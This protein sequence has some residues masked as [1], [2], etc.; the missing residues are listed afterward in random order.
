MPS[1]KFPVS[2]LQNG[3]KMTNEP[4]AGLRANLR[5]A[6]AAMPAESFEPS[7]EMDA[8]KTDTWRKLM[9]GLLL[10]NAVIL[11]RRKFGPLGW[12][13]AYGFTDSD[14]DICLEQ[15]KLLVND[16]DVVPFKV[17][18]ELTAEVNYGGRVTDTWDRRTIKNQLYDFIN[19]DVLR[20]AYSFSPSGHYKTIAAE[21]KEGY[22]AMIQE[23]PVNAGPEVFGLHDNADITCAQNETYTMFAAI[24]SLQPRAASGGGKTRE[25]LLDE[26]ADDI[27][28]KTPQP[29][30]LEAVADKYPTIYEDSMNTVVQ[31][32]CIRYNKVIVIIHQSLKDFRKALKGAV[33]MTQELEVL[34]T[35]L[36]NNQVP[37]MWA[38]AAYPSMKPLGAWVPDLSDRLQFLQSWLDGGKPAAFWVSGFYFPQAFLTGTMQNHA[39]KYQLPIDTVSFGYQLTHTL[40]EDVE[41]APTNGV[42]VFGMFIEG[43]RI[44]SE[45]HLLTESRSKELYTSLPMMH[46]LPVDHRV[47]PESG[48]FITTVYKTLARFGVLSTTG[49]STNFVMACELASDRPQQHWVKRGVAA[50]LS[51]KV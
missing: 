21:D 6:Y 38:K 26:T 30:N 3:V 48:I 37:D 28:S 19:A 33:V 39:R 36:F 17:V 1:G 34:G 43:A 14:R 32:E 9:F 41:L 25:E 42:L 27:L 7:D 40:P 44:D 47:D 50:F 51:L 45:T 22:L 46:L 8:V 29:F 4:P 31:Q 2:V 18:T 23:L 5:T 10:F 11:E 35:Q 15:T 16:Y 24:L 20:E 12:N 13:I 49:H